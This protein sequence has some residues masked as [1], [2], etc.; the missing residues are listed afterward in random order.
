MLLND[1]LR[2]YL[3]LFSEPRYRSHDVIPD[4]SPL[5]DCLAYGLSKLVEEIK[6]GGDILLSDELLRVLD[7]LDARVTQVA[8]S[9]KHWAS[10]DEWEGVYQTA[11]R[12][13]EGLGWDTAAPSAG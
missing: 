4:G 3:L 5:L 12:L 2:Q 8:F 6:R 9:S 1:V 11:W 7:H 13:I 10:V